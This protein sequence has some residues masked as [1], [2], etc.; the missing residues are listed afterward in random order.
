MEL[1]PNSYQQRLWNQKPLTDARRSKPRNWI[2]ECERNSAAAFVKGAREFAKE[3]LKRRLSG[4]RHEA[5]RQLI[6]NSRQLLAKSRK[7]IVKT[8]NTLAFTSGSIGRVN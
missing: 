2:E 7:M 5:S 8:K 3:Q 4:N 1:D 6:E